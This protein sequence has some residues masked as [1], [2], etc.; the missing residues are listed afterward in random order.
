ME[1]RLV[2]CA[3]SL[4]IDQRTNTLSLFNIVEEVSAP[5]FPLVIP[6]MSVAVMLLR[7]AEEPSAPTDV[8]ITI[9]LDAERV[10]HA[11]IKTDFQQQ[12][13]AKVIV[14][15]Q[16]VVIARAGVLRAVVKHADQE[17]GTWKVSVN[18]IGP[19]LVQE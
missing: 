11:G 2:I 12:L 1:A 19:K 6:Y 14:E 17:L 4:S 15:M 5:S 9:Y 7:S 3:Q 13:R 8:F 16:G 10:L 18:N